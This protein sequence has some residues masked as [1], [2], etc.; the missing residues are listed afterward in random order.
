[1]SKR[2]IV[3]I[4]ESLGGGVRKHLIDLLYNINLNKYDV[5]FIYGTDDRVDEVFLKEKINFQKSGIVFYQ[6]KDLQRGID[7]KKDF[8]AIIS[9]VL[10]L[11]KIKP[12]LIHCHSSKAGAIG[13]L[14]AFLIGINNVYYTPHGYFFL[15]ENMNKTKRY[16]FVWIEK[17]LACLSRRNIHVS[18]GEEKKA[19]DYHVLKK[20]KS[21]VIYNGINQISLSSNLEDMDKIIIGTI[22]RV[23]HQKN[24]MKF[25]DIAEQMCLQNDNIEFWYIG[26]GEYYESVDKYIKSKFLEEKIKLL[27]FKSNATE[28]LSSFDIFLST[29]YYEGMPYT[30]IE[31]MSAGIPVVASNV[32]GNNEIVIN[33]FN[34]FTFELD[35]INEAIEKMERIIKDNNLRKEISRNSIKT[36]QEK[37]SLDKMLSNYEEVYENN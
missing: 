7:I 8:K 12:D 18:Y 5:H 33:G 28:Y 37:Y 32:T 9:L 11:K 15:N 35:N 17:I 4:C 22:A 26:D 19:L 20:E 21:T 29:S 6:I 1:M 3:Y 27:G 25:V 36:F 16:I 30:L 31:S 34:G 2:K 23:D 14:S 10:L 13:R 24:P